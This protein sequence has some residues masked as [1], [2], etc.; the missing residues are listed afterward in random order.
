MGLVMPSETSTTYADQSVEE[1]RRE[2]AEAREQQAATAEILRVISSSPMDLPR[3][4]AEMA[5]S[6]ARLCN[7]NDAQIRQVDG[8]TL[9][10]VAQHGSIPSY[11]ELKATRG[12]VSGRAV[13]ERRTIQVTDLDAEPDEYPEGSAHARRL[14][15]RT[16]LAVPLIRAGAATGVI[17]IRRMEARPFSDKQIAL[18]ETFAN[19]AVIA[20][21]N[22]RLFEAEQARTKEVEAKSAELRES[23]EYQTATSE[24]LNV[25]SRSPS[26]LQPALDA[27]VETAVRLCQA[28]VADF[29]LLR[30]GHYHIEATTANEAA[31]VKTLRDN[32][33]GPGRGSVCGRAALERR[34]VHVED[35]QADPEYT[36]V[37]GP[38]F[39]AMRAILGV[40]LLRDGEAIGVIVLFNSIVKPFTQKQIDLVTTFAKQALIAIENARLFEAEQTRT[41]ELTE[42]LEYQTATSEVLAVIS[43]SPNALQPVVDSISETAV[44]LCGADWAFIRTLGPDGQYHAVSFEGVPGKFVD[45]ML[46]RTL[47]PGRGLIAGRALLERRTIHVDDVFADPDCS[48]EQLEIAH[49]GQFH[50][51]LAVPLLRAGEPIGVIVLLRT[52]VAPFSKRQ[53]DLVSTFADQAEIAINNVGLFEEVQ[54]RTKELQESLEYQTA[55]SEVLSVISRSPDKLQPVL[56]EIAVTSARLCDAEFS[57]LFRVEADLLP[58]VANNKSDAAFVQYCIDHPVS[59]TRN[60][61]TG[62]AAVEGHTIHTADVRAD[63]ENTRE[64][65]TRLGGQRTVLSVPLLGDGRAVGVITL[66]RSEVKP[67][68][69][70]Q[71]A[72]VETFADQAVIAINNVGLFE[73]VQARTREL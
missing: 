11:P 37:P 12:L 43:R 15:Y 63:P 13:L 23:L 24:V 17:N 10:L 8:T 50:T 31:R 54:A 67:F 71:I 34:T 40:P 69:Q 29:R 53:I 45:L 2:L 46:S 22:T 19:Q 35:I 4:F 60:S 66:M 7:A 1:L 18:L 52:K 28:D 5:M 41:K 70:R 56:D 16:L 61:N 25:I 14:G 3:V 62:R 47:T 36:Y 9:R 64:E 55:T 38:N 21:E 65:A 59:Y 48:E 26:D 6:A 68:T 32:P 39:P 58:L 72:L 51:V 30:G 44:R 42:S 33:I 57:M 27:I 20:I 73:E 49:A